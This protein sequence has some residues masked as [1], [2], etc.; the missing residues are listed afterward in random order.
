VEREHAMARLETD[1]NNKL[2]Y[3]FTVDI[4]NEGID[5]PSLNQVIML[6]PTQSPIVFVQQLGRGLRKAGGKEYLTIIDFIGN[7]KNNYMVPI[8]L[9]GDKSFNK[10]NLRKLISSGSSILPG[11]STVNFDEI[12][13]AKIFASINS[14]NLQTR[15]AL[16][17]DYRQQ[18]FRIGRI[19]MMMDFFENESR[20]ALQYVSYSRSFYNFAITEEN[21]QDLPRLATACSL[22]L[23]HLSKY[24]ND[25]IRG[26]DSFIIIKLIQNN[27]IE[28]KTL[29]DEFE[30]VSN[31]SVVIKDVYSAVNSINLLFHQER[32]GNTFEPIGQAHNYQIAKIDERI[33]QNGETL[34]SYLSNNVFRTY[35]L[36]SSTYSVNIYLRKL[37]GKD[38]VKGFVRYQKYTRIDVLR[39]L[40]WSEHP[41]P[42]QN[43]G[44]YKVSKDET[45][46]PIFVTYHKKA[47]ITDTTKYED[48]FL[49]PTLFS[50]MSRSNR[51]LNSNEVVS[52]IS[53]KS[54]N[55]RLPLFIKKS[56]DEGQSHY[57]LGEL[58]LVEG[59][60][61]VQ[62]MPAGDGKQVSVVNM[63]FN[64]DK[65]VDSDL[66]EFLTRG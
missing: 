18:K 1:E 47:N 4:F 51:T 58:T 35:L 11:S 33:I 20:D 19:P 62:Y 2:D 38:Y 12:S 56:D 3:I 5:I 6:R 61:E 30:E 32:L 55:I 13:K 44:G 9:Y 15:K 16:I 10:D 57:Y 34:S 46:C 21:E 50:W 29:I 52:I 42:L 14:A 40:G 54:N 8:A 41:V 22:L 24:V 37:T 27:K 45:N 17:E 65:S 49:S 23:E 64:I 26:L 48:E 25:G 31:H 36:D 39:I 59:S 63:K 7:Y 66:Y 53:Q 43:V 60:P 28:I